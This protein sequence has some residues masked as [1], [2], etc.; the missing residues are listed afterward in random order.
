[1]L[2]CFL[3]TVKE[4]E[5]EFRSDHEEWEKLGGRRWK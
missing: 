1:M 5:E 2:K 4:W 3:L